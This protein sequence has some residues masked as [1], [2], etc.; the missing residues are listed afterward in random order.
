MGRPEKATAAGPP[1]GL[2]EEEAPPP[3]YV[4]AD[5]PPSGARPSTSSAAPLTEF[6]KPVAPASLP[7]PVE[8]NVYSRSMWSGRRYSLGEHESD[9]LYALSLHSGLSGESHVVLHNG[10]DPEAPPLAK[11]DKASSFVSSPCLVCSHRSRLGTFR[12]QAFAGLGEH[13]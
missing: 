13:D 1:D 2:N 8:F 4:E 6:P 10:P 9:P 11:A 7:F 5:G 3:P 12:I